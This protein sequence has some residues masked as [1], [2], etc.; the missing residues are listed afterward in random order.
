MI[1]FNALIKKYEEQGEKTGWTYIEIPSEISEK[2]MPGQK[3]SFR[4][5]GK[6]DHH[7]IKQMAL[8]PVGGGIFILPLKAD[9]RKTLGKKAGHTIDV[10]LSADLSDFEFSKD[11]IECLQDDEKALAHF[12]TLNG[13]HQKYLSKWIDSAKTIET[14]SKRI[15]MAIKALSIK[16][17]YAEMIRANKKIQ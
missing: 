9:L 14:K 6:L 13:S 12:K 16:Q 4:V 11:F 1:R 3:V 10:E 17:G 7:Q 5:K 15:A 8:L 2:L